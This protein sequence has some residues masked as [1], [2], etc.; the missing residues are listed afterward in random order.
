MVTSTHGS[1][2][3]LTT[4]R[5]GKRGWCA[6]A[7]VCVCVEGGG[8]RSGWLAAAPATAAAAVAVAVTAILVVLNLRSVSPPH[9]EHTIDR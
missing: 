5:S 3:S 7:C 1:I 8:L 2:V 6:R 4:A 9:N